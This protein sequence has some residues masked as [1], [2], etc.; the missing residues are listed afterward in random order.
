MIT[1]GEPYPALPPSGGLRRA[2]LPIFFE[3]GE[4]K[5]AAAAA[6][7]VPS[8]YAAPYAAL[9]GC[10]ATRGVLREAKPLGGWI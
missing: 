7:F 1:G 5:P 6:P 3:N 4:G 9:R 8:G 2:T 10:F